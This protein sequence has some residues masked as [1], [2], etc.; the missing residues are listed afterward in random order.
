MLNIKKFEQLTGDEVYDLASLRQAVFILEQQCLYA[1]LDGIDQT[2]LHCLLYEYVDSDKHTELVGCLR[3]I[4]PD[5]NNQ[6]VSLGRLVVSEVW[7]SNGYG[8]LLIQ[9]G[10]KKS[11]E[12]W[13]ESSIML[14]GQTYLKRFYEELGFVANG[15]V[16]DED[17]IPHQ[18][19][20]Y[21]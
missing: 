9:A 19:F 8:K 7:R 3:I 4:P 12:L 21:K 17:G 6:G 14:S 1:D 11:L 18:R 2:S 15:E 13:P 5:D 20:N 16:Y 10:T